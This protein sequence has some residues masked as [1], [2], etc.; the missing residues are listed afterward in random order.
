VGLTGV[1]MMKASLL[2]MCTDMCLV[3]QLVLAAA[4]FTLYINTLA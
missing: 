4:A 3:L 2:R 1:D